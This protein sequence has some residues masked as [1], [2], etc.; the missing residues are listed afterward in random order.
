M[1]ISTLNEL[2]CLSGEV[3][4]LFLLH[5]PRPCISYLSAKNRLGADCQT[6][7]RV[8]KSVHRGDCVIT[9]VTMT[10][11][12]AQS[13]QL[14]LKFPTSHCLPHSYMGTAS[15]VYSGGLCC[16]GKLLD[17]IIHIHTHK[18]IHTENCCKALQYT[19]FMCGAPK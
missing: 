7:V 6:A 12:A 19:S 2:M 17:R 3:N 14:L 13:M 15:S 5:F 18:H 9:A 8:G 1:E 4:S 10:Q 11:P 16:I